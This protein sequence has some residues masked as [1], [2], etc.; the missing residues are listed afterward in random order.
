MACLSH[1]GHMCT[2]LVTYLVQLLQIIQLQR[3]KVLLQSS[4]IITKWNVTQCSMQQC[5]DE[6]H[7]PD[8]KVSKDA[9]YL[10][11][12]GKLWCLLIVRSLEKIHC[13]TMTPPCM[14]SINL[15]FSISDMQ[16][17]QYFLIILG[18]MSTKK[19]KLNN[20]AYF[21]LCC[22]ITHLAHG[23][24]MMPS[25]YGDRDLGQHWLR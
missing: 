19:L 10:T 13:V 8:F 14:R 3:A 11:L 16:D 23:G 18:K 4:T 20:R 1:L 5:S 7:G 25:W 21:C 17:Y 9:P 22:I 24:L 6:G 12:K 2:Y 15:L